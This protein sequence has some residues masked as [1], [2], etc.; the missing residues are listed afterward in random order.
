MREWFH[1]SHI[2]SGEITD[3]LV[4]LS[5]LGLQLCDFTDKMA[6]FVKHILAVSLD[7]Y[8]LESK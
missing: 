2:I 3:D 5:D 8:W 7:Q 4:F 6:T 1:K